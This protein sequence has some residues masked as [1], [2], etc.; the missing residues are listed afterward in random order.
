MYVNGG[1]TLVKV[2]RITG[3]KNEVELTDDVNI[4]YLYA[5]D[6]YANSLGDTLSFTGLKLFKNYPLR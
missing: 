3:Y 4:I 1:A 2:P 6:G 5:S